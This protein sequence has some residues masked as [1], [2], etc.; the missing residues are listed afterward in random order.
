[1]ER[2]GSPIPSTYILKAL[3]K[4]IIYMNKR[5]RLVATFV[6][7]SRDFH[8]L[9]TN[10]II[11]TATIAERTSSAVR[12]MYGMNKLDRLYSTNEI[13]E[14]LRNY[15]DVICYFKFLKMY[16]FLM[17]FSIQKFNSR[18][19]VTLQ[20]LYYTVFDIG[21]SRLGFAQAKA[22]DG[23]PILPAVRPFKEFKGKVIGVFGAFTCLLLPLVRYK[24]LENVSLWLRP[25]LVCTQE[26]QSLD[27]RCYA[28]TT[29]EA[30]TMLN[31]IS[32]PHWLRW[33]ENVRYVPFSQH[34]EDDFKVSIL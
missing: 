24:Q 15:M 7:C 1:M 3:L 4:I 13:D 26:S 18:L 10:D 25:Q 19:W 28:C 33:L 6:R 32:D 20:Q 29:I 30:N 14:L 22:E 5:F 16:L 23:N 2:E 8:L 27:I 11:V 31:E 9:C 17:M 21:A 34:C 12:R